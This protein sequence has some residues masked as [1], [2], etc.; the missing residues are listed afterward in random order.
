MLFELLTGYHP[1]FN[2]R[3]G[4]DVDVGNPLKVYAFIT[5]PKHGIFLT[6]FKCVN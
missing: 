4:T 5:N 3:R 6:K 1:F 2:E